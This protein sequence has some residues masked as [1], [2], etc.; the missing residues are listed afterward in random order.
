MLDARLFRTTTFRVALVY[1]TLFLVSVATILVVVYGMTA[2]L[3]QNQADETIAVELD[4]LREHYAER[5]LQGLGQ[6]IQERAAAPRTRSVYLLADG[7]GAILAG[8]LA[9]WPRAAKALD[10]WVSFD[11]ANPEAETAVQSARAAAV[12]LP[13]GAR[14]LVG[15]DMGER[16]R[17]LDRVIDALVWALGLTLGL[18]VAGAVVI[19]RNF[20]HRIEAINRTTRQIMTGELHRRIPAEG[21]DD[22]LTR[23][24]GNLNGMLDQIERLMTGMRHVSDGIAHDLRTPLTRL[25]ARLELALIGSEDL[26]SARAAM[27]DALAEADRLL[28]TFQALLSIAEAE[29]GYRHAAFAPVA[30]AEI[31]R[32]AIDLYEPLAEE[33]G[34]VISAALRPEIRIEGHEQLLAQA[35]VNL[36][37]NAVKYTPAGGRIAVEVGLSEAGEPELGVCDSG[38]GI[39]GAERA[40][41]LERFVRLE[42]SRSTPGNGLGLSLVDAVARLHRARLVMDDNDPGLRIALRFPS[43]RA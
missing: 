35:A 33:K 21:G 42:G 2:T 11:V 32:S 9:A 27:Q 16:D 22:E 24:A 43:L 4:G 13:D 19:S 40:R 15:R 1:L 3:L 5:G 37:D 6:V 31:A 7:R 28:G 20:M 12:A 36:I 29:A 30:L 23:L 8:N 38:P 10:D 34:I 41:V 17:F 26:E 25:R 39:P 18:G 14:L